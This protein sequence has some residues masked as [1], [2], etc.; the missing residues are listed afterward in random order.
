MTTATT[1][2][3][4]AGPVVGG[5][6]RPLPVATL[7]GRPTPGVV[8]RIAALDRCGRLAERFVLQ[9]LGWPAG[10]RLGIREA[11]GVLLIHADPNGAFR[12]TGQGHLRLPARVRRWCGLLV[13]DR[14]L[15]AA[16]PTGHRRGDRGPG[17]WWRC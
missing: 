12:T 13:G 15:L 6:R 1:P 14:V 17:V 8:Y 3:R 9:A 10:R 2:T 4:A 7:R 16:D 11:G 5:V